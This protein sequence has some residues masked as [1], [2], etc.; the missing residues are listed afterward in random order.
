MTKAQ[1]ISRSA[2]LAD[3]HNMN[4]EYYEIYHEELV[5]LEQLQERFPFFTEY[6]MKQLKKKGRPVPC[7]FV[8]RTRVY[9]TLKIKRLIQ[10]GYFNI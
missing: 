9:P 2:M 7:T 4:R 6:R 3:I 1:T 10:E 5:E 8:C